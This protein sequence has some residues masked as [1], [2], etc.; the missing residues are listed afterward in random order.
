MQAIKK[1]LVT[2]HNQNT[3]LL[4]GFYGF[5]DGKTVTINLSY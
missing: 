2:S 5:G 1:L 3:I 4:P